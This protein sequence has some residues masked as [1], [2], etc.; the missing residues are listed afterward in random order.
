MP[1]LMAWYRATM[2]FVLR[3]GSM[4]P[5]ALPLETMAPSLVAS[6]SIEWA[7]AARKLSSRR[8]LTQASIITSRATTSSV[9]MRSAPTAA[10]TSQA[11]ASLPA[12]GRCM[13]FGTR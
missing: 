11:G 10:S 1:R 5:S 13:H 8:A 2:A 3:S 7:T 6:S 4:D 9:E 12:A